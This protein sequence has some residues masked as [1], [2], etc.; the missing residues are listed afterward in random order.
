MRRILIPLAVLVILGIQVPTAS[1]SA[2][3]LLEPYVVN[4]LEDDD[5]EIAFL[6]GDTLEKGDVLVGMV[7]IN[8]F[9]QTMEG[10]NKDDQRL[11]VDNKSTFTGIFAVQVA[12]KSGSGPYDYTF[13]GISQANWLAL[14]G[15]TPASAD[16]KAILWSDDDADTYIDPSAGA[17]FKDALAT[18]RDGVYLW[19][20]GFDD[21]D[22][23][24]LFWEARADYDVIADISGAASSL[25]FNAALDVTDQGAGPNLL[26]F[27]LYDVLGAS[28]FNGVYSDVAIVGRNTLGSTGYFPVT[29]DSEI[30]LKPTPEPGT[31]ALL[32]LGLLGLGGVVYR[33]RRS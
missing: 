2:V 31:L 21:A 26:P 29:T 30:Y 14:T 8:P 19:E 27:S 32:G 11:V 13:A 9:V 18:A 22:P 25:R 23:G 12:S 3:A 10:P 20:F 16:T 6:G 33:R 7:V 24:D 15:Y 4:W 5:F 17:N 28:R 1:A